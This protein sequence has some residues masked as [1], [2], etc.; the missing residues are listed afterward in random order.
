MTSS[1][2]EPCNSSAGFRSRTGAWVEI[3]PAAPGLRRKSSNYLGGYFHRPSRRAPSAGTFLHTHARMSVYVR[4]LASHA[5]LA[6][7]PPR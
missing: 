5:I 1:A 4:L 6:V 2:R 3:K 7:K